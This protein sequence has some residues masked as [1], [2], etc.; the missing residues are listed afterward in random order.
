MKALAIKPL[1][2]ILIFFIALTLSSFTAQ[3]DLP[4]PIQQYIE[5]HF[6]NS[7]VIK[8]KTEWT[9]IKA[10]YKV[11][12]SNHIELE[13]GKNFDIKEIEGKAGI[14]KALIPEKLLAYINEHYPDAQ[15]KEWEKKVRKQE[16]SLVNG[17]EL[18]FDLK[19]NFLRI[20]D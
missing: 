1:N 15:L 16:V 10:K 17:L 4:K 7:K 11:Y 19:G 13:F 2:L 6:Q 8:Y 20:D 5:T 14:P 12:L 3:P 18:E 9:P